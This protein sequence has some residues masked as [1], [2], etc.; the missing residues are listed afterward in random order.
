MKKD[1]KNKIDKNINELIELMNIDEEFLQC[2]FTEDEDLR[3]VLYVFPK[4]DLPGEFTV[5]DS[6][7]SEKIKKDLINELINLI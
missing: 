4:K 1:I 5:E 2:N 7:L 3:Y 6:F